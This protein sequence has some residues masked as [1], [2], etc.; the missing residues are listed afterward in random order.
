M[1]ILQG[2]SVSPGVAI[3]EAVILDAE[4]YRIPYRTVTREAHAPARAELLRQH[5]ECPQL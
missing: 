4:D 5:S 3:G 2:I 1:E